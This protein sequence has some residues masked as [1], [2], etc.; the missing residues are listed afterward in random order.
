MSVV[1]QVIV[2]VVRAVC[3]VLLGVTIPDGDTITVPSIPSE[4]EVP[5]VQTAEVE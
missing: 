3:Y 2:A 5:N 4:S 1:K